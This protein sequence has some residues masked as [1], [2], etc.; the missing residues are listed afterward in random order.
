MLSSIYS[1]PTMRYCQVFP[2][3]SRDLTGGYRPLSWVHSQSCGWTQ[4]AAQMQQVSQSSLDLCGFHWGVWPCIFHIVQNVRRLTSLSDCL[5]R[6]MASFYF[7]FVLEWKFL[8]E[9]WVGQDQSP[10]KAE[11]Y[12]ICVFAWPGQQGELRMWK[13][14]A[15]P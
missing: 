9:E 10:G 1:N 13:M 7:R 15:F 11:H 3:E 8:R 5:S 6:S 12:D 14:G 2:T 4:A